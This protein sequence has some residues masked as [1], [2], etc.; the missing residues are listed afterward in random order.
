M[1]RRIG[2]P[3][4]VELREGGQS[5]AF[6][7]RGVRYRVLARN[8]PWRL[9]DRRWVSLAEADRNGGKG[10]SDRTYYRVR[11]KAPG[12]HAD[13]ICDLYHDRAQ[14]SLWVLEIVHD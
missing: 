4:H 9:Q 10:F 8:E 12:A 13:L 1:S 5:S 14:G 3:I 11:V 2:V 6:T 7:W